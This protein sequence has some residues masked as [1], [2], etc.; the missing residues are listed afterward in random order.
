[1]S[2][3]ICILL[4]KL[5]RSDQCGKEIFLGVPNLMHFEHKK[6]VLVASLIFISWFLEVASFFPSKNVYIFTAFSVL[7]SC[8]KDHIL[9]RLYDRGLKPFLWLTIILIIF[10]LVARE[11]YQDFIWISFVVVLTLIYLIYIINQINGSIELRVYLL[12]KS[13]RHLL[14][15]LMDSNKESF[16]TTIDPLSIIFIGLYSKNP[17]VLYY[18]GLSKWGWRQNLLIFEFINKKLNN[19]PKLYPLLNRPGRKWLVDRLGTSGSKLDLITYDKEFIRYQ[20]WMILTY[21][22]YNNEFREFTEMSRSDV[23]NKNVSE[24]INLLEEAERILPSYKLP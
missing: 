11:S 5:F 12:P 6:L 18:F 15:L 17:L 24:F 23:D 4:N 20:L 16:V 2:I 7:I 10:D 19:L 3:L 14:P 1:M 8:W 9:S 21:F 22:P 13:S